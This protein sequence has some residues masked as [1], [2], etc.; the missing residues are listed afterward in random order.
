MPQKTIA[1]EEVRAGSSVP[2]TNM[3]STNMP[4]AV[5]TADS[6][7]GV[8]AALRTYRAAEERMSA[9]TRSAMGMGATDMSALR[10]VI[11]AARAGH[12]LTATELA[13]S[14]NISTASTTK[15]ID[16]LVSLGHVE[17]RSHPTDRRSLVL[18]PTETS[19]I[20]VRGAL[21]GAHGRMRDAAGGLSAEDA[22]I[23]VRF[24]DAATAVA[25]AS[26]R[27]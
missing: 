14:L 13:G 16:R 21:S 10:R 11:S 23:L 6:A 22:A 1:R 3:P 19:G 4:S 12:P 5:P 2:L 20:A 15:L 27:D 18:E 25:E 24:F 8:L 7:D 26:E 17:R 9:R